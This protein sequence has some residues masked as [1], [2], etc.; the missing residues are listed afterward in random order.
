MLCAEPTNWLDNYMAYASLGLVITLVVNFAC[1]KLIIKR[2]PQLKIGSKL[3]DPQVEIPI[4]FF[5]T[6]VVI[7]Q[8]ALFTILSYYLIKTFSQ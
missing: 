4:F 5:A 2:W 1:Y 8:T 6:Y 3:Y 7:I